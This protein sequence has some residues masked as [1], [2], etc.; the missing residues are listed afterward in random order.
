M[1][2]ATLTLP[3]VDLLSVARKVIKRLFEA[4]FRTAFYGVHSDPE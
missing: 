4:A 2:L 3:S 1:T